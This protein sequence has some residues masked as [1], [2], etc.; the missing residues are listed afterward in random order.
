MPTGLATKAQEASGQNATIKEGT[1][2]PLNESWHGTVALPLPGQE[3]F[4][5]FGD[6]AVQHAVFG[7][8]RG[9]FNRGRQH[10]PA[11]RQELSQIEVVVL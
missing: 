2:L 11:S 5:L 9:V 6:D 3:R 10:A 1:E 8:T 4:K 7:M